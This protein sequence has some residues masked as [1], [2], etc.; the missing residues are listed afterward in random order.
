MTEQYS[1]VAFGILI[2][3]QYRESTEGLQAFRQ[4]AA[5]E[6]TKLRQTHGDKDRKALI[7]ADNTL[8]AYAR[9]YKKYNKTYHVLPQI[10]S[11]LGGKN[12]NDAPG[13]IQ[14]LLLTELTTSLLIAGHDLQRLTLPLV[15]DVSQHGERYLTADTCVASLAGVRH[16]LDALSRIESGSSAPEDFEAVGERWDIRQRL[17]HELERN[18][19]GYLDATTPANILSGGEAMRVALISAMLSEAD[20]LILDEPSNHLDRPNRQALIKQL[21]RWPR[22]LLIVSHDRQVL[23]TMARIVE[24][25]AQ[26][27]RSYGGNYTAY[28]QN[29]AQERQNALQ[30]L[31]QRKLERQREEQAMQEQRQ[32]QERRQARGNRHGKEANQARILLDR[33][34]ARSEGSAGKLRR[35]HAACRQQLVNRVSEAAEQ[36]EHESLITLHVSPVVQIARRRVAQLD[37]VVLPFV[38]GPCRRINLS[39]RGQQR[40][41]VVGPNGCGKSTL[42]KVLAGQLTPLSGV[43]N[44][45]PQCVYLD[46]RLANLDPARPALE[47]LQAANRTIGEGELR[48]RLAQLGLDAQNIVTPSGSLSGG[49]R[50]KAALACVLYADPPPQLLLL[51]EPGNHL[52][53]PST[54]ALETMLRSYRGTL[55]VVSHDDAFMDNLALTDR[56]QA[57]EQGWLSAPW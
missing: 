6:L 29:K 22:G 34:K 18:G 55:V 41:G 10:E 56:L 3:R 33:Q 17:Q 27:L 39:L 57:S 47:Q 36:V 31:E 32:R 43:S 37:T 50:L 20:F 24:L 1:G 48:M 38:T 52:D 51:D 46:Q 26:G 11:A 44:V 9:Y 19:L 35:L 30:R 25:S 2:I 49:E 12:L 40:V 15:I 5:G 28:A 21:Q 16:I 14:A 54:L 23:E 45:T 13:L 4:R 7:D 53:L 8:A 42:L